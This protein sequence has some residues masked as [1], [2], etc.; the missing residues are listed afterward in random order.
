MTTALRR[1]ALVVAGTAILGAVVS[2]AL[3]VRG[4]RAWKLEG[5]RMR[6]DKTRHSGTAEANDQLRTLAD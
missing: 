6:D 1:A 5:A 3:F 4:V 2:A